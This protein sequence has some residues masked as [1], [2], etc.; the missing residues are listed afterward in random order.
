MGLTELVLR[1]P[2]SFAS[3]LQ[4]GEKI[5]WS[6][7]ETTVA[8][9]MGGSI[10]A[11]KLSADF[12]N[13]EKN[14]DF[15]LIVWQ[16]YFLPKIK[17]K[18]QTQVFCFSYSGN[19]EE[20]LSAFSRA[21]ELGL[22]VLSFGRGGQLEKLAQKEYLSLPDFFAP[23]FAV[24]YFLG[25][26]FGVLFKGSFSVKKEFDF[27]AL[28][29]QAIELAKALLGKMVLVYGPN[30]LS[31][32][33]SFWE[34]NLDETAKVPAFP[35]EIPDLDH[36]DLAGFS[37]LAQK[38]Q[39]VAVFLKNPESPAVLNKRIDL[40][41]DFFDR[42]LKIKSLVLTLQ[43]KDYFEKMINQLVLAYLCSLKIAE[44]KKADP[45][46]NLIQERLKKGLAK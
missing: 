19:T 30:S 9:G 10:L 39:F 35:G 2:K 38:D 36:H 24:P 14:Q 42:H 46:E 32:L 25:L 1:T 34:I 15:E 41:A 7:R 17:S 43:G 31:S 6:N 20:T 33:I 28:E 11:A 40:T 27:S 18:D 29:N 26:L 12:L 22:P 16:D 21:K 23:R 4:A 45:L 44:L 8:A 13:L 5:S 37:Q 3:G